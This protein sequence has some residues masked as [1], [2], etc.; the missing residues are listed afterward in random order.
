MELFASCSYCGKEIIKVKVLQ[1]VYFNPKKM[2]QVTTEMSWKTQDILNSKIRQ[3]LGAS[4][5]FGSDK[6]L[7]I[8]PRREIVEVCDN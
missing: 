6:L 5:S 7:L 8:E 1:I 2:A 4:I 3:L